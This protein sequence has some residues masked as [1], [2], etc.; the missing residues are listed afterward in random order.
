MTDQNDVVAAILAG[1]R[2]RRMGGVA[3]PLLE[4]EGRTILARLT[5]ALAPFAREIVVAVADPA[6]APPG[7]RAIIDAHH[8]SGPL[9]GIAAARAATDARWLI[10][11][12]GDMPFLSPPVVA[13]L[14]SLA[15]DDLDAIAPRVNGLPEPL[16]AVWGP[17]AGAAAAR[18]L[19]A[20][21]FKTSG[22]L[23]DEGL[24][25]AWLDE[26]AL[27]EVDPSLR[28]LVNVNRPADLPR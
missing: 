21:R 7:Y 16:L 18:R 24:R 23:T 12:A 1:G 13:A 22:L 2:A 3:K 19:A 9:A 5:E 14:L 8:D 6:Q 15:R 17:A 28:C 20:R 4:V 25:V 11:V 10:A 27:R 26:P